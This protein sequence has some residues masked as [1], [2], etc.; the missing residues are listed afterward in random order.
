MRVRY[1]V[2]IMRVY[3]ISQPMAVSVLMHKHLSYVSSLLTGVCLVFACLPS[4]CASKDCLSAF[5]LRSQTGGRASLS[6]WPINPS[7]AMLLA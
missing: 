2:M 3:T 6:A 5:S 7:V 4:L 1:D